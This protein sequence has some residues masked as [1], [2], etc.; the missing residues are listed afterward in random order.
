MD[1]IVVI[2]L[3]I[4]L[5]LILKKKFLNYGLI[6]N[7]NH[8]SSHSSIALRSGGSV[9]FLIIILYSGYLYINGE[10]PYDF[11]FLLP[12]AILYIIGLY[13]DIKGLDFTLKFIFQIISAK[14]LIDI[15]YVIDIFSVFGYEY[16]FTRILSQLISII[17]FVSIFNAYNFIDGIDSNIHL[18]SMKNLIL[19]LFIFN[20]NQ[21]LISLGI[22][23][24]LVIMINLFFNLNKKIKIFT[25]DSGSLIIPGILIMFIFEGIE[26]S[27]DKN[28]LKYIFLL[29]IYPL[30]D[31]IRV[32]L[33]R[34]KNKKSPFIPDR[35]H[36]HHRVIK[37]FGS[38]LKS[39][40]LIFSCVLFIQIILLII[41]K[42]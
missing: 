8:R 3:S 22:Y 19:I 6:D 7:I 1:Y 27:P 42:N 33:I 28:S 30:F 10:Q 9:I 35:N 41:I 39:S 21:E 5:N 36:L 4:A 29:F 38:H 37:N 25:G 26:L 11:S 2:I 32:V 14:L 12:L 16:T 23:C 15:G 40:V 18:E 24:V 34:L 17:V 31:L 13:D 20:L